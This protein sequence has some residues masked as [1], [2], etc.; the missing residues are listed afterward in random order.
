MVQSAPPEPPPPPAPSPADPPPSFPPSTPPIP[1]QQIFFQCKF[2]WQSCVSQS[3][4]EASGQTQVA[5]VVL[6]T[7]LTILAVTFFGVPRYQHYDTA[8]DYKESTCNQVLSAIID[9]SPSGLMTAY[10]HYKETK[11]KVS[12]SS[13]VYPSFD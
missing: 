4:A 10:K 9:L 6:L 11:N 5:S 2:G 12:T 7:L 1:P 3:L 13:T 8:F